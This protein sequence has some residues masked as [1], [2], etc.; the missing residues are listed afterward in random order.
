[1]GIDGLVPTFAGAD[2]VYISIIVQVHKNGIF[3]GLDLGNGL[4]LP[5]LA[6]GVLSRIGVNSDDSALFPTCYNVWVIITIDVHE[7]N[8][9]S[10]FRGVVNGMHFPFS[11]QANWQEQEYENTK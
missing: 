7:T 11:F 4:D 1:M 6:L 3:G 2:Y 5:R 8:S 9:I 10:T